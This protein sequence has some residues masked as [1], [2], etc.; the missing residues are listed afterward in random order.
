MGEDIKI[1]TFTAANS[2]TAT[3]IDN[4]YQKTSSSITLGFTS[5]T[6]SAVFTGA[7]E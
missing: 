5:S 7:I 4:N 2:T 1:I 6:N 3:V